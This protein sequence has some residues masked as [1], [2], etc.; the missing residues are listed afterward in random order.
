MDGHL[1]HEQRQLG[2]ADDLG[3]EVI[4]DVTDLLLALH[5]HGVG[6]LIERRDHNVHVVELALCATNISTCI[7]MRSWPQA[8]AV[9]LTTYCTHL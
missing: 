4:D 1:S 6:A 2:V 3:V 9:A 8:G 7:D 5:R